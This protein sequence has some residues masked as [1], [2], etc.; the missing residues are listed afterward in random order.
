[1][2]VEGSRTTSSVCVWGGGGGGLGQRALCAE[3]EEARTTSSVR[4]GGGV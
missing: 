1:M 4:A 3:L 2:K